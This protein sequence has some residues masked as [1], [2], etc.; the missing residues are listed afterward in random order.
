MDGLDLDDV[1]FPKKLILENDRLV[2]YTMQYFKNSINV[3]DYLTKNRFINCKDIFSVVKQSSLILRKIH[4]NNIIYQ[5]LS[6][7]NMLIDKDGNI[8]YSDIDG[9]AYEE[10]KSPFISIL[11][12][13]FLF[14]YK[15]NSYCNVSKN[16]DRI[17]L[18]LSFYL[19][20]YLKELQ[21]ISKKKYASLSDNIITLQ[22]AFSYAN[23]LLKC[24][25]LPLMPYIDEL[26]DE[27]D[28]YIIDRNKQLNLKQQ[29]VGKIKKYGF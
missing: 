18:I 27:N 5:D 14:D 23:I 25:N 10:Y 20:T 7:D 15:K 9:C 16:T 24:D 3:F 28:N 29:F 22:N 6:F 12:K 8:K 11:L 26:I 4:E 17:S 21:N 1:L 19:V 2:G 13:K